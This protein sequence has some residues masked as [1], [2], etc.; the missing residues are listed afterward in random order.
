VVA[1][2]L[3]HY[4]SKARPTRQQLGNR[5]FADFLP[6]PASQTFYLYGSRILTSK[7]SA[8]LK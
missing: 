4:S 1:G 2:S 3:I 5:R 6:G 8:I 7:T